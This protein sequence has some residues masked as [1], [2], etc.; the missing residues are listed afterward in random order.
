MLSK[1]C[2]EISNEC[3]IKVGDI[4]KL[5]PNLGNCICASLQNSSVVFVFRNETD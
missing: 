3:E 1:Y 5:I 2:E 4:K